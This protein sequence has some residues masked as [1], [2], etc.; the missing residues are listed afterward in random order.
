MVSAKVFKGLGVAAIALV[1]LFLRPAE[2]I[3]QA[4]EITVLNFDSV[5]AASRSVRADT[6]LAGYGI[7]FGKIQRA[8]RISI[9][10]SK[11]LSGGKVVLPSP[12]NVLAQE[13]ANGEIWYTLIFDK[14]CESVKFTRPKIVAGANGATYPW[15]AA[16]AYS[17]DSIMLS[18]ASENRQAR[19]TD[20]DS[21]IFTLTGPNIKFVEFKSIIKD[22]PIVFPSLLVDDLTLMRKSTDP[23]MYTLP[24]D[25]YVT[26]NIT[27]PDSSVVRQLEIDQW[28]LAG[29]HKA[30]WNGLDEKGRPVPSGTYELRVLSHDKLSLDFIT[31]VGNSSKEPW[32]DMKNPRTGWGGA[33]GSS[34][35]VAV[36]PEG[37][38]M[39]WT[40]S[41]EGQWR[42]LKRSRDG[43]TAIW[44]S[45]P[46]GGS[47]GFYL[48]DLLVMAFDGQLNL[49]AA[50][51]QT[52]AK[53]DRTN[54]NILLPTLVAGGSKALPKVLRNLSRPAGETEP[55]VSPPNSVP[56]RFVYKDSTVWGL[57]A[58]KDRV[59][60]SAPW[61]NAIQVYKASDFSAMPELNIPVH[62]PRGLALDG[63]GNILVVS[64]GK[65]LSIDMQTKAA[66]TLIDHDLVAPFAIARNPVD[67]TLFVTDLWEAQQVKKFSAA[68]TLIAAF[69]RLGGGSDFTGGGEHEAGS[70]RWPCAVAVDPD[71]RSFWVAEDYVPKRIARFSTEDGQPLYDGFGSVNFGANVLPNPANISEVFTTMMDVISGRVDY[72]NK[73]WEMERVLLKKWSDDTSNVAR[74]FKLGAPGEA[75]SLGKLLERQGRQYLW[76]GGGLYLV[77]EGKTLRTVFWFKR[78]LPVI[79]HGT[80]KEA[81]VR[82]A[83]GLSEAA[84]KVFY[85]DA[86]KK[87]P[88]YKDFP[89]QQ[90]YMGLSTWQDKNEDMAVTPDEI[91]FALLPGAFYNKGLNA[92]LP[93]PFAHATILDDFT[94][95]CLGYSWKP[96][97]WTDQGVPRYEPDDIVMNPGYNP[98]D[99][100]FARVI[101][102]YPFARTDDGYY[103]F[104]N[105]GAQDPRGWMDWPYRCS[106]NYVFSITRDLKPR[107]KIGR[108]ADMAS[109]TQP[110]AITAK[111]GEMYNLNGGKGLPN[112][113]VMVQDITGWFHVV[114][115]DG[116]YVQSLLDDPYPKGN[117]TAGPTL[118]ESDIYQSS[119]AVDPKTK[120]LYLYV[121]NNQ[122]ALVFEI[123]NLDS[124]NVQLPKTFTYK[125]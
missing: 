88:H 36:D 6:Y 82:I 95:L 3:A 18:M 11:N 17:A 20:I 68:G 106:E 9:V 28:K 53:L 8:P 65:V 25:A 12:P 113:C 29:T 116:F 35:A 76:T 23:M 119:V 41:I 90:A 47:N 34:I 62:R 24:R 33:H 46:V 67:G 91:V 103:L 43:Q 31:G 64:D 74:Q 37:V 87:W 40:G 22:S 70:F 48:N 93:N 114:H 84:W 83:M 27:R 104:I 121:S 107:W 97:Y 78:K 7:R 122:A 4:L 92:V 102:K 109:T 71:G 85:Y 105:A 72:A 123:R 112:G 80:N 21:R 125:P 13:G 56:G 115:K 96:R 77:E 15:W 81:A 73:S 5:D 79:P 110:G 14:P 45:N 19:A 111:P 120:K 57:A 99:T 10:N 38:Y 75:V 117:R 51:T 94:I 61:R 63:A 59:Y 39:G 42:F 89:Y 30:S 16:R 49:Y 44:G 69:G 108:H 54:G 52:L 86:Y 66:R 32:R 124:I 60:V 98:R 58:D 26:L 101:E 118:L 2:T 50:T 55:L 1:F 100:T